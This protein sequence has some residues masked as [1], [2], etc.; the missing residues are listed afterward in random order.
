MLGPSAIIGANT[1]AARL[2][3]E[4]DDSDG[5]DDQLYE[6]DDENISIIIE[7][8]YIRYQR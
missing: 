7:D 5:S 3:V 1:L 6:K 4:I 2:H 8:E